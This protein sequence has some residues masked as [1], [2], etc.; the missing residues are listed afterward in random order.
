MWHGRFTQRSPLRP[1]TEFQDMIRTGHAF[2]AITAFIGFA[3]SSH[4]G[5]TYKVDQASTSSTLHGGDREL[6]ALG[7]AGTSDV[8]TN[9]N[10]LK[11]GDG[12][13]T[14]NAGTYGWNA[15]IARDMNSSNNYSANP[16]RADGASA[17]M[18]EGGSTGALKEVF[19]SFGS[20]Y[21]NM[22]WIID[23]E[24]NGAWTLDLLFKAGQNITVDGDNST[25]EL[26]V[27]ERGGNSDF[28]V[29]GIR[30]DGS[31][32]S[33]LFVS[34]T[35]TGKTGWTLDTLEIAGAQHVHGVG[36]SL[37]QSWGTLKGIRLKATSDHSGPDIVA[38]G[39]V[40]AV[41]APGAMALLGLAGLAGVRRR[42]T[43]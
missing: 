21:K 40:C 34:R 18:G 2:A 20:G 8:F 13:L 12:S 22:S 39:A 15:A 17:Y 23:G 36:I 35:A 3:A 37:D 10:F 4:A 9:M 26:A 5:V 43:A 42:R 29:Y 24:D 41:P 1:L 33:S 32:T 11:W 7:F 31:L 16:D 30:E 27:L 38:V 6:N 14:N 28:K 25:V 19:G